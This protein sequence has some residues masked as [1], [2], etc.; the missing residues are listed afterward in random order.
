MVQFAAGRQCINLLV[1]P[2]VNVKTAKALGLAVPQAMRAAA[3]EV[4]E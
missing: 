3:D 2:H 4:I 1:R